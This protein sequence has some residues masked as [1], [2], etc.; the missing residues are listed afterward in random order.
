MARAPIAAAMVGK[1]I[2]RT[3]NDG[4]IPVYIERFGNTKDEIFV[5]ASALRKE[6]GDLEFE[7]IPTGALG[8]YTYYERLAQGLRQLM[9]GSRKFS[10]EYISRDDLACLTHQAA[11]ISGIPFITD[12]DKVQVEEILADGCGMTIRSESYKEIP[13][14]SRR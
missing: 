14:P 13:V 12:V 1:T 11:D 5:T 6:L 9:C 10:L 2:G 8:L 3:I 4:Q 7:R